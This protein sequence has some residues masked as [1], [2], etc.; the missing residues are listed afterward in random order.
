[1]V[2]GDGARD[3]WLRLADDELLR[4]CEVDR[5][6]GSGAGG[7]KRNKTSSAVRI[8]HAPSGVSAAASDSR[9]QHENRARAIRRLREHL[10]LD[11][12]QPVELDGFYEPP[13]P[14][15]ALIRPDA[16]RPGPKRRKS[17]EYLAGAAELLDLFAETGAS[18]GDTARILE[19]STGALSKLLR[20][21]DRLMRKAAEMRKRYGLKPLR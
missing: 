9:S 16:P 4:Q 10:A 5:Y 8:R 21:D 17:A 13:P 20:A 1:M 15:A 14:L 7:Q 19:I 3:A 2:V 18:L 11:V 6:R 12:R